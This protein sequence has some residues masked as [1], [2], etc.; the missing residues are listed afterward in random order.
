MKD[1]GIEVDRV[2]ILQDNN[3]DAGP[4]A[5]L[6]ERIPDYDQLYNIEEEQEA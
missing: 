5:V 4:F 2:V 6:S 3:E 1:L